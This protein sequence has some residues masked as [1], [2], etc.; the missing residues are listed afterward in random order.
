MNKADIPLRSQIAQNDKWN[1]SGLF[2]NDAEWEKAFSEYALRA[3][4]LPGFKGS[5]GKSAGSL[6]EYLNF[7]RDFSILEERLAYYADLRQCEDEG[8]NE[9]RVMTGKMTIASAKAAAGISWAIPEIQAIDND[10]IT[11]FLK[12]ECLSEYLIYLKIILRWKPHILTDKEERLIALQNE[13]SGIAGDAFSVLTNVDFDF[14]TIDTEEGPR[15]LSQSTWSVFMESENRDLRKRAYDAF[16]SCYDSHKTTLAALYGG[17]VKQDVI[18]ARIRGF[19]S[20]REA[21][22]FPDNVPLSVYDNLISTISKNLAPLHRYYALKK[23][24]L[25]L[26]RM[27]HYD[28]YAPVSAD[29]KKKTSW[30]EAVELICCALAPLGNEYVNTLRGGLSGGWADKYENKGKRSGAFS[31][32]SYTAPP[33]IL[34][35]YKEDSI[36][37]VFTLAHE[38]GHS[39][40]SFYSA[41]SNPFSHYNYSIFEAEVASTFNEELL[42][43]YLKEKSGSP[44]L[45]LYIVNKRADDILA[46]L[47]R[48]T[49]FAEF[50]KLTHEQEERGEPLTIETLRSVYRGLLKKYFGDGV[51]LEACSDL[52]AL[53]IPHFYRAFYVYKYSTGISASLALAGRV[54]GGG[55]DEREDYFSFLSSGGSRFPI[56]SLKAAGVDMSEPEPVGAACAVFSGLVDEL[57]RLLEK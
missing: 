23:R 6:A 53:R 12:E 7:Y 1:L 22:L 3:E 4:K 9:A 52:E 46:T 15:P 11:G 45:M 47:Y 41:K 30:N 42:Y 44:E 17:S 39:M 16:Y 57:E 26:E 48:Q 32:G 25:K 5:L 49:M 10:K 38:G 33:Y 43:R 14:G 27:C 51:E 36:R 35:N 29:V 2:A 55:K 18:R 28:V 40:H 50:E 56:D 34:M 8:A 31:A 20:A 21:A 19:A 54:L 13:A 24:T 37:D